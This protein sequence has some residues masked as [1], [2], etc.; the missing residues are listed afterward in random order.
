MIATEEKTES[1]AVAVAPE[2]AGESGVAYDI[3]LENNIEF[4]VE[5]EPADP[6]YQYRSYEPETYEE[7][8]EDR[9][10]YYDDRSEKAAR[11]CNK[12]IFTWLFSF[13]LGIYG[14]DRFVRGQTALGILKLMTFGGLGFWYLADWMIAA[15]KSYSGEYRNDE[16]LL[17]DWRGHYLD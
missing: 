16:D 12:H 3:D 7:Y 17:F 2:S 13:T 8:T 14:I 5:T 10:T 15:I 6:S 11:K 1:G 4:E 9:G